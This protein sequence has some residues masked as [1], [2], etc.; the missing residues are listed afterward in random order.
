MLSGSV[1]KWKDRIFILLMLCW[2]SEIENF[3]LL[4]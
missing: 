3:D 2:V 1:L 4:C